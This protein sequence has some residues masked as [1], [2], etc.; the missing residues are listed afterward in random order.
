M[1]TKNWCVDWFGSQGDF[2]AG[3]AVEAVSLER[4]TGLESLYAVGP[5][6]QARGEVSIYDSIPLISEVV[7]GGQVNVTIDSCRHAAF[8]VYAI[9]K[10]WRRVT[11]RNPIDTEQQLEDQLLAWAMTSGIDVDQPLAFLLN[12]RVAQAT[13]HVL[14]NRG[15][16]TYNAVQHEKAKVRFH[17]ANES[18]E[19]V[20]FYSRNHRGIFT[21]RDSNF[22]MHIRTLDNRFA[23]H[24]E[25]FTWEHGV[26]LYLPV[27]ELH[28]MPT[29]SSR[30]RK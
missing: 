28:D 23:G 2:I 22:H 20:G 18:V 29:P 11:V 17:I 26:M 8:L 7:E 16:G 24:L 5:L 12:G 9:V 1:E 15:R 21:P 30:L 19:V 13:F 14:C 4:F 3:K 27:N 6:E 10:N 25:G